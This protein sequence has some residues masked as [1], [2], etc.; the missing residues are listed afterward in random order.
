ML[1]PAHPIDGRVTYADTGSPVP[2][3][4]MVAQ[5]GHYISDHADAN[6]RFRLNPYAD[7]PY[8]SMTTGETLFTVYAYPPEGQPYLGVQKEITWKKG[9]VRQTVD[10]TLPRGVLVRGKVTDASSGK[11]VEGCQILYAPLHQGPFD[12]SFSVLTGEWSTVV[13]GDDGAYSIPVPEGTGHLVATKAVARVHPVGIR[14]ANTRWVVQAAYGSM[15]RPGPCRGPKKGSGPIDVAITLAPG[16]TV[17]GQV[18]GPD[19]KPVAEGSI[20]TRFNVVGPGTALGR[21]PNPGARRAVLL[22]GL[23]PGRVYPLLVQDAK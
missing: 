20:I 12:P 19:D 14:L 6:G 10:F 23:E 9:S 3:A 21:I 15:P 18:N 8:K 4:R 17:K 1:T 11:P 16:V 22:P 7:T 13:S 5:G 2:H